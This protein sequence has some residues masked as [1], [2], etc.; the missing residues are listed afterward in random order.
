MT[1]ATPGTS[2]IIMKRKD[3]R[4]YA[5]ELPELRRK[6]QRQQRKGDEWPRPR[7]GTRTDMRSCAVQP[8]WAMHVGTPMG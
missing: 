5:D 7:F 6:Q 1:S 4:K 2:Y 3:A 8:F